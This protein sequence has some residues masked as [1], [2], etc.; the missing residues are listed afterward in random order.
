M[1]KLVT[2]FRGIFLDTTNTTLMLNS[3]IDRAN[4]MKYC[5]QNNITD[6]HIYGLSGFIGNS[7][8]EN[9]LAAFISEC[10]VNGVKTISAQRG[11]AASHTIG[12]SSTLTYNASRT[13]KSERFDVLGQEQEF[14]QPLG[15][16]TQ[17]PYATFLADSITIK[18]AAD[19]NSLKND[20][21]VARCRDT[22]TNTPSL[23]IAR[24]IV[25]YHNRV[26]LTCY[27]T[28][29]KLTI[30]SSTS[31]SAWL[32]FLGTT[33]NLGEN[34]SILGQGA[35]AEGKVIDVAV[36]FNSKTNNVDGSG[37]YFD[38]HL[39]ADAWNYIKEAFKA[40]SFTGKAGINLVGYIIY[41]YNEIKKVIK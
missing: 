15:N 38:T 19:A 18:T 32:R 21:Y 13:L 34:L 41:N 7:V 5:V 17:I 20:V 2:T 8:N 39:P 11:S 12:S 4:F 10:R 30:D 33:T 3:I 28:A 24:D 1:A 40:A 35:I 14:W 29:D 25:K 27:V 16:P 23:S 31:G 26:L 22:I 37:E 6:V 36:I 9:K